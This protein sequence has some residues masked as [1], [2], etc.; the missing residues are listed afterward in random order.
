MIGVFSSGAQ[1]LI[2]YLSHLIPEAR[3]GRVLGNII[4]GVLTSVMLARPLA[5]F[6]SAVWGWRAVYVAS[7]LATAGL[8]VA[9]WWT[10]PP[11]RPH[12]RIA[13]PRTIASMFGLFASEARVCRRTIYQAVLFGCFTMFWAA[14]PILLAER[15]GLSMQAIGLFALA[16]AGGVLAAPLAGRMA[17]RGD[18]RTGTVIAGAF[19]AGA[20]FCSAVSVFWALPIAIAMTSFVIDGSIQVSQVL[21]RMVVLDVAPGVRGRVNALYMTSIYLSGAVGSLLG[22]S[23]YYAA[24]WL[25]ISSVG[26]AGGLAVFLMAMTERP[27]ETTI[28]QEG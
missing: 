20:F 14:L 9:L 27:S 11:R 6:V 4:A 18:V 16:G 26:M 19:V 10:M 2:P 7:G 13:Y 23:L 21:S 25:A 24:G 28:K 8:G 3:R 5:L 15:F 12:E 22:V 17:D 1:V